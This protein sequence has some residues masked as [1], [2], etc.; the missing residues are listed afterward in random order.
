M[1]NLKINYVIVLLFSLS[2][3][4]KIEY[5]KID[6][7]A[8]LRVFNNFTYK[9]TAE[10]KNQ[11]LPIF[12]MLIDPKV[13]ADGVVTGAETIGDFLD[14]RDYYAPPYPSHIGNSTS[15][16]N[17]EYPGKENVLVGP[18]LNGFDLSS[19]AQTPSGKKRFMFVYRPKSDVPFLQLPAHLRKNVLIDTV[20]NMEQGEVY[21]LHLLQKDFN[22]HKNGMIL[23]QE[24]FHKLPLADSLVYVNIYNMSA[25]GFWEANEGYKDIDEKMGML[26]FGIKDVMNVYYTLVDYGAGEGFWFDKIV[27]GHDKAFMGTVH[28]ETETGKVNPYF[29]FP[30]FPGPSKDTISNKIWQRFHF[31]QPGGTLQDYL[32]NEIYHDAHGDFAVLSCYGNG[33]VRP[34]ADYGGA[35]ILPNLLVNVHSGKNNPKTFGTVNTI[36]IVNGRV[37]LTTIQRKY[38]PPS[39]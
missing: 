19:W 31:V 13:G 30:V 22:T 9:V 1:K 17:P 24:Q 7:P 27:K 18:I 34:Y 14:Q 37:F 12:T 29:S 35:A 26:N 2:A 4:S 10:N 3:C 38:A 21:T 23:R 20:L 33:Q 25:K 11:Q 8:Y 6:S 5:T 15:V 16:F 28:R 36:E 39:Y 32:T